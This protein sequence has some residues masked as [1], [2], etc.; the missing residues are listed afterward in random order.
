MKHV[1]LNLNCFVPDSDDVLYTDQ[2]SRQD[3]WDRFYTDGPR[4][5]TPSEQKD[6]DRKLPSKN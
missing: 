2:S 5:R 3:L 6:S 1:Q 4:R